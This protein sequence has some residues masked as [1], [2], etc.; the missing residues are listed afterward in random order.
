MRLK[1]G[2]AVKRGQPI[3]Q[4]G[5]TGNSTEPHLH[6][7]LTDGPDPLQE[8]REHPRLRRELPPDGVDRDRRKVSALFDPLGDDEQ[9]DGLFGLAIQEP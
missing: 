9:V 4:L 7:Q 2:D 5:Q 6:F 1:A 8:R 3:A